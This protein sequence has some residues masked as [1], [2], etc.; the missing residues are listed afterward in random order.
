MRL[1]SLGKAFGAAA[2][3]LAASTGVFLSRDALAPLFIRDDTAD[4]R[5]LGGTS[6]TLVYQVPRDEVIRFNLSR[7]ST[8]VRIISQPNILPEDWTKSDNWIYGFKVILRDAEGAPVLERDVYSRALHPKRL[9]PF[10][11]PVRFRLDSDVPIALRDDVVIAADRPVS[12]MEMVALE[13]ADPAV[14]SID[15]QAYERLPFVGNTALA[16]F[17]RRSASEQAVL[18]RADALGPELMT[19]QER[20]ALM[21]NRWRALGPAGIA[22]RDYTVGV[23]YERP[24][25]VD[26]E[27][28]E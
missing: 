5:E 13:D 15:I 19:D 25:E 27:E 2:V 21:T 20:A 8:L 7:P 1:S 23:V 4:R 3:F 22:G 26:E 10:K 28:E 17:R 11:R 18:A 14:L 9:R 12:T 6:R 24:F 16:A